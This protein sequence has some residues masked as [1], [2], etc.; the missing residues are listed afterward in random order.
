MKN[1]YN[2]AFFKAAFFFAMLL[3][4]CSEPLEQL[5]QRE[6]D[7]GTAELA[8]QKFSGVTVTTSGVSNLSYYYKGLTNNNL[9]Y[10]KKVGTAWNTFSVNNNASTTDGPS[11]LQVENYTY[12]FHT[13]STNNDLYFSKRQ[14]NHL[15]MPDKVFSNKAGTQLEPTSVFFNE[16]MYVCYVSSTFTSSSLIYYSR[17]RPYSLILDYGEGWTQTAI[18][19]STGTRPWLFTSG[20]NIY[21]AFGN[22]SRTRFKILRSTDGIAWTTI[23]DLPFVAIDPAVAVNSTG[24]AA[25]IYS[26]ATGLRIRY[27]NDLINWSS[28]SSITTSAGAQSSTSSPS[29]ITWDSGTNTFVALYKGKTN[30]N[31][32]IADNSDGVMR[33]RGTVPGNTPSAPWIVGQ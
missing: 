7:E 11:V 18:N 8:Q 32:Y 4:S 23:V 2:S 10:A 27:S 21:I 19:V 26:D 14:D 20:S 30:S 29:S 28:A 5:D 12:L 16:R 25:L 17:S 33:E 31:I 9:Y 15:W 1:I 3:A 24:E 6:R 22:E 13:G